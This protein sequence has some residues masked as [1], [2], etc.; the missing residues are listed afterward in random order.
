MVHVPHFVVNLVLHGFGG[1]ACGRFWFGIRWLVVCPGHRVF[2]IGHRTLSQ[3]RMEEMSFKEAS[4]GFEGAG[5]YCVW[6][7]A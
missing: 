3:T 2:R 6:Y 7:K 1:L 5:I 4:T